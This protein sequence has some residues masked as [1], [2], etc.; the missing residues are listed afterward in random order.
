MPPGSDKRKGIEVQTS[1]GKHVTISPKMQFSSKLNHSGKIIIVDGTFKSFSKSSA[2]VSLIVE[3][4]VLERTVSYRANPEF[5]ENLEIVSRQGGPELAIDDISIN[6]DELEIVYDD[7]IDSLSVTYT[8]GKSPQSYFNTE[9]YGTKFMGGLARHFQNYDFTLDKGLPLKLSGH[10]VS[11]D[12]EKQQV[13]VYIN[14]GLSMAYTAAAVVLVSGVAYLIAKQTGFAQMP[15]TAGLKQTIKDMAD[16]AKTSLGIE[17]IEIPTLSGIRESTSNYINEALGENGAVK[18]VS[19]F[20]SNQFAAAGQMIQGLPTTF[21]QNQLYKSV[22]G[23][24]QKQEQQAAAEPAPTIRPNQ[25]PEKYLSPG[26]PDYNK[27][28]F[29][30]NN[31]M[32][33]NATNTG[34]LH[35]G[36]SYYTLPIDQNLPFWKNLVSKNVLFKVTRPPMTTTSRR[37]TMTTSRRTPTTTSRRTT[38]RRTVSRRN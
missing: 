35:G 26:D 2:S 14:Q 27:L 23:F 3:S 21:M 6:D 22:F 10:F 36:G 20:A 8:A 28:S 13:T 12:E 25:E 30:Q 7:D 29:S 18:K 32:H 24:L 9:I 38:S 33:R 34:T 19:N 17:N 5:W 15:N 37:T 11:F 31:N 16:S 4:L 1:T